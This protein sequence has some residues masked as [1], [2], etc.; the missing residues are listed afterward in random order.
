MSERLTEQVWFKD[1]EGN[2]VGHFNANGFEYFVK[3]NVSQQKVVNKLGQFEDFMEEYGFDSIESLK[4]LIDEDTE[5][6][7]SVLDHE[8]ELKSYKKSWNT[9]KGF[10][11]NRQY[12]SGYEV[13]TKLI[14]DILDKME[15]LEKETKDEE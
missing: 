13:Q 1:V 6:M 2:T 15:E 7:R 5:R 10:I 4:K 9:L 8:N 3:D 12:C 11:F 14:L